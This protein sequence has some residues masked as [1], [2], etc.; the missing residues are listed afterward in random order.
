MPHGK[1]W[2]SVIK[3]VTFEWFIIRVKPVAHMLMSP[4]IKSCLYFFQKHTAWHKKLPVAPVWHKPRSIQLHSQSSCCR[5]TTISLTGPHLPAS[6]S[7][8]S[9]RLDFSEITAKK[10]S[11]GR[12]TMEMKYFI[13]AK[14]ELGKKQ[15]SFL[16]CLIIHIC[17]CLIRH[18][19]IQYA[20]LYE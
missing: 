20:L 8:T 13:M 15:F 4:H 3:P 2:C 6:K 14:L 5:S 10:G 18:I 19:C 11:T 7:S 12:N 16:K 1:H 9:N 17:I